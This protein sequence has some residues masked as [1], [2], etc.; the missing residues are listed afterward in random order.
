MSSRARRLSP[1]AR[2]QRQ[3]ESLRAVIESISG[4]LELRPLLT[5]VIHRACDLLQ[6][7][8][9]TI[10][11]VDDER[12]VVRTEA[13]YRMPR[14]ELGAEMAPGV[15]IAGQV[16]M[17]RKPL[18]VGRYGD[19][20]H[21]TQPGMLDHTVL[22]MPIMWRGRM[23]GF[24]GIGREGKKTGRGARSAPPPF[25]R[26]DVA[27]L[28]VFARHAAIA[29]NNARL[30][31][32]EQ[33]RAERLAL[34][35]R[36]G[37]IITSDLRLEEMLQNAADAVHELL[38][39]PSIAI[40]IIDRDDPGTLVLRTVGGHY[41]ELLRGEYRIPVNQGIMGAAVT[42]RT[43]VLVNDVERDPRYFPAPFVKRVYAELAVPIVL[44]D[45]VLGVLNVE[46][47]SPLSATDAANLQLVADQ[48]GVAIENARL[49]AAA[50]DLAAVEERTRLARDL[51][52]SVT[53]L[54][55]SMT[56]IAQSLGP[57]YR[58]NAEEGERRV[59]RMLELSHAALGEMRALLAELR[60][61]RGTSGTVPAA[62]G[63]GVDTVRRLGL[64]GAL[65]KL[66]DDLARD[67]VRSALA[68]AENVPLPPE[69]EVALYHIAREALHNVLKHAR[70]NEVELRLERTASGVRLV[71]R[72]DGVGFDPVAIANRPPSTGITGGLGL[73]SM[74][75]RAEEIGG[76]LRVTSKPGR[77]TTVAVL[78]PRPVA[79]ET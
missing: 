57:A 31:Q 58:R 6:A 45:R 56:L 3:Q 52:D 15:G 22:G 38:G 64:R 66:A 41:R 47:E 60:P 29:I 14:G 40:P 75:E 42:T 5:R 16:Y 69:S 51:H 25:T 65:R 35:T 33:Q 63:R 79:I 59:A 72:D 44:A 78:L 37:R 7:H 48:L 28:A 32:L 70:A 30:F 71:A 12:N 2:A 23:I 39:Y 24:F 53:Q 21:P 9:G 1:R 11:L 50:R 36:V 54:L 68:A 34:I 18:I 43:T 26:D 77:G 76:T 10:G 13:G 27:T 74:R 49:H 19:L 55:F 62:G 46:S 73:M 4:G 61:A 17:R 8:H 67:G 20:P